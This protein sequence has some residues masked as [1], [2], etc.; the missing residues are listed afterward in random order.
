M[1]SNNLKQ[2]DK[3]T[4]G[5][6]VARAASLIENGFRFRKNA[7]IFNCNISVVQYLWDR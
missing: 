1:I 6:D 3:Q 7:R 4:G 2:C 5:L